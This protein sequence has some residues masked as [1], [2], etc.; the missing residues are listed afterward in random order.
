MR[1][2]LPLYRRLWLAVRGRSRESLPYAGETACATLEIGKVGQAFSLP[3]G[4]PVVRGTRARPR[5]T[6]RIV[7]VVLSLLVVLGVIAAT[8]PARVTRASLRP[9]ERSTDSSLESLLQDDPLSILGATRAVYLDGYGVVFSTEV[10]LSP[11]A[12]PNPFRPAF[13]KEEIAR[14]KEKKKVRIAFLKESMR[15]ILVQFA[16]SLKTVPPGENVALAVTIPYYRWEDTE[17][18]PLQILMVAP[19]KALTAAPVPVNAVKVQEFY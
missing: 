19:R 9:L 5:R 15:N 13:G 8:I 12:A 1:P 18:M 2:T 7:P 10:E 3:D 4:K 17:G 14:L 11:S 16:K 6:A